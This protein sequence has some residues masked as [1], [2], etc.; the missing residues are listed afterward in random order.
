VASEAE[1]AV[2]GGPRRELERN[3]TQGGE[4]G[5]LVPRFERQRGGQEG[6]QWREQ[7]RVV[8]F[9]SRRGKRI[10][11]VSHGPTARRVTHGA[12]AACAARGADMAAG[13]QRMRPATGRR[14]S[15][16]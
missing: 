16:H 4:G 5:G 14:L 11:G 13:W 9:G 3:P 7:S 10:D 6:W 2:A 8:S 1:E 15:G 12:V